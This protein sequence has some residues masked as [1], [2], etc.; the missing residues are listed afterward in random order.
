[1]PAGLSR[2]AQLAQRLIAMQPTA[3]IS[4]WY[5]D[6]YQADQARSVLPT[7]VEVVCTA[8]LPAAEVEFCALAISKRGEAELTRDLLQQAHAFWSKVERWP[9]R[10]TTPGIPGYANSSRPCLVK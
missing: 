8:D 5:I 4:A 2:R 3:R 9:R 10:S 1:M 7:S 6:L